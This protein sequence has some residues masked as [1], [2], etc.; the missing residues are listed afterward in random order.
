PAG[1]PGPGLGRTVPRRWARAPAAAPYRGG[2]RAAW[3]DD[4]LISARGS[5]GPAA[6]PE[7][8]GMGAETEIRHCPYFKLRSWAGPYGEP[9]IEARPPITRPLPHQ[10][11]QGSRR[12]H[13]S[14]RDRRPEPPFVH[15]PMRPAAL[16]SVDRAEVLVA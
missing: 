5:T 1:P 11:R 7:N 6:L 10:A 3:P 14:L 2:D 15:D 16:R 13:G 9:V 8:L 12:R 4:L